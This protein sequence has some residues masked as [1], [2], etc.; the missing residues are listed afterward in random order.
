MKTTLMDVRYPLKHEDEEAEAVFIR[1]D[2]QT[3]DAYR[4]FARRLYE[5]WEQWGAKEEVLYENVPAIER[6]RNNYS[7]WKK[8]KGV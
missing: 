3:N 8:G 2:T 1:I 7:S 6:W 4:I 5:S